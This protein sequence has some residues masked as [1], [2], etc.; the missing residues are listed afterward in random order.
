MDFTVFG[1]FKVLYLDFSR[2]PSK[3]SRK[4]CRAG[5]KYLQ[6]SFQVLA[7]GVAR[8]RFWIGILKII[9]PVTLATRPLIVFWVAPMFV[10]LFMV[11]EQHQR[12][13]QSIA[14]ATSVE[15]KLWKWK[16]KAISHI[17]HQSTKCVQLKAF[18]SISSWEHSTG[19][20]SGEGSLWEP[21][22][23]RRKICKILPWNPGRFNASKESQF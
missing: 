4:R 20:I 8:T 11:L 17:L 1:F 9:S 21:C 13:V 15:E 23:C 10:L 16:M 3:R 5:K 18:S 2:S 14:S 6:E 22:V 7:F 19:A 12:W